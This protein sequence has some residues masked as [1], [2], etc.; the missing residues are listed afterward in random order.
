MSIL[1]MPRI[2][3]K[4]TLGISGYEDRTELAVPEHCMHPGMCPVCVLALESNFRDS[5]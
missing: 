3:R 2:I 5:N 1:Y 4:I